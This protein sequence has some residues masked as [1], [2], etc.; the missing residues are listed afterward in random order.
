MSNFLLGNRQGS[1]R[2]IEDVVL[3]VGE[4]ITEAMY[5]D[6]TCGRLPSERMTKVYRALT[7]WT[8]VT[9]KLLENLSDAQNELR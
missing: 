2:D 1:A 4:A 7:D 6:V 3:E 5:E 8:Q 9:E